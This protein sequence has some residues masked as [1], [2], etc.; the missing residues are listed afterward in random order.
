[1]PAGVGIVPATDGSD[2]AAKASRL[3]FLVGETHHVISIVLVDD[4]VSE[5]AES[6]AV[7]LA[8]RF[9]ANTRSIRS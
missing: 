1:V 9:H 4:Q 7:K 3:R 8:G 6:F 5:P 2:Y